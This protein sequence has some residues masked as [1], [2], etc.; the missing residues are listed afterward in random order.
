MASAPHR[1]LNSILTQHNSHFIRRMSQCVTRNDTH[2]FPM[3]FSDSSAERRVEDAKC[4]HETMVASVRVAEARGMTV[5][6]EYG[7]LSIEPAEKDSSIPTQGALSFRWRLDLSSLKGTT[8]ITIGSE[9]LIHWIPPQDSTRRLQ[10]QMLMLQLDAKVFHI[11]GF[12]LIYRR[13]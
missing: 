13:H 4:P 9:Y 2:V 8:L 12:L 11:Y 5:D 3:S 7:S 6:P 1:S 10:P